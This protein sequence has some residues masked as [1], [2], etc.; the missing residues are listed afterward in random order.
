MSTPRYTCMALSYPPGGVLRSGAEQNIG[1]GSGPGSGLARRLVADPSDNP[2][3]PRTPE[4]EL[5]TTL[6]PEVVPGPV[7]HSRSADPGAEPAL[8]RRIAA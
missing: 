5:S 2:G 3:L 4:P 6:P 7:V 1:A 8:R